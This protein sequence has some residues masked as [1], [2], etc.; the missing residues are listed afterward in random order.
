M[1]ARWL[2]L[3]CMAALVP[4]AALAAPY[5]WPEGA[6]EGED[7]ASRDYYNL[8]ARL[9]W[10]NYM[11]DWA[12]ATGAA[13]G[14]QPFASATIVDDNSE[15]DLEWDVTTLVQ[16]W[17]DGTFDNRGFFL[18]GVSGDGSYRFR[19][20]E[21]ADSATHPTLIVETSSGTQEL[22]PVADTHLEPSTYRSQGKS[23]TIRIG[24]DNNALLRFDLSAIDAAD[25]ITSATLRMHTFEQY[26][27]T[28]EIG[29]FRSNH[30][31]DEA[32]SDPITGLAEAY[33]DDD[34]ITAEGDVVFFS[35][36]EDAGWA[37][38]WSS[39]SGH[40]EVVDSDPDNGFEPFV[41]RA[42]R[43]L[44]AEGD[45]YGGSLQFKF[46][47]ELGQEPEEIYFRY[48]LRLGDDWNQTVYGGK[49][50]GIAGTYDTAGWGG[51]P[52]DGTNGWS[53]RGSFGTTIPQ[54]N[55]LGGRHP[56][57]TYCYHADMDG[58]YGD[59]WQWQRDYRGYLRSNEWHS[60]E[61]YLKMNTPGETDGIIR[62]WIDGR[63][64]FEK[65][66]IRFRTVD[67]LKIETVWMNVYHGGTATSPYDQ[68]LYIDNVVIAASYI[69]PVQ[70]WDVPSGGA[71]GE[72][73]AGG[74]GGG[75][76]SGGSSGG[77]S[78]GGG[79]AAAGSG[80]TGDAGSAGAPGASADSSDDGGCGCRTRSGPTPAGI[81]ALFPLLLWCRRRW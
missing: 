74:S 39:T 7:G 70:G 13:Q 6:E 5:D 61:Q 15:K 37:D 54:D 33:E 19:T 78:G 45:N 77:S 1:K 59:I 18:R 3:A 41:G 34:G 56:L 43:I 75:A 81:L 63:P 80:G 68:H 26:G 8:A 57:G 50:P 30:G 10:N 27:S 73:G 14:D 51:R 64:A 66:D 55:P 76:G 69:G 58:S 40:L 52:S 11:G 29:V 24:A 53:A 49:M 44:V 47:E 62:S 32:P 2:C 9:A 65:T 35:D 42:L 4:S 21:F 46:Q 31:H 79:G 28:M 72:G 71:G 36:F 25:E 22:A 60:V 20:R 16:A 17:H 12:D 38:G 23:E 67:T 48:Y